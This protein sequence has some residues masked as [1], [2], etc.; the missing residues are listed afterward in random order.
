VVQ[1]GDVLDERDVLLQQ[2]QRPSGVSGWRLRAGQGDQPG[3]DLAGHR[4]GHRWMLALLALDRGPDVAAGLGEA[5]G[6]QPQRLTRDPDPGRDRL[7]RVHLADGGVQREQ[8]PRPHD[9]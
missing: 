4:G 8:H 5:F 1:I 2:P 7:F 6:D 3:L 9:H